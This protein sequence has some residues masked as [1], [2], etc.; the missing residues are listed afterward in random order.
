M[1]NTR[2]FLPP[3]WS[4]N[5]R[6]RLL[7]DDRFGDRPGFDQA[8]DLQLLVLV[9]VEAR[10]RSACRPSRSAGRDSSTSTRGSRRPPATTAT[11]RAI[12]ARVPLLHGMAFRARLS[13]D[14]GNRDVPVI[15]E[16][17]RSTV[18]G[19]HSVTV[20]RRCQSCVSPALSRR[21][22]D[23]RASPTRLQRSPGRGRR[24]PTTTADHVAKAHRV[25]VPEAR[26]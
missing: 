12:F 8:V 19:E 16:P 6:L 21:T 22:H 18:A 24:R 17:N 2:I 23:P 10:C 7:V 5:V 20:S 14:R 3:F 25:I 13:G 26:V 4:T 11:V 15:P 1:L 9:G